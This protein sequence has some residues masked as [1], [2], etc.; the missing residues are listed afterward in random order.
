MSTKKNIFDYLNSIYY[1]NNMLYNKSDGVSCYLLSLWLS[2]D[3]N[4]INIVQKINFLQFYLSDKIIYEYY[5]YTVPKGRRFIR[6]TKKDGHKIMDDKLN[7][8]KLEYGL[9]G[10]ESKILY[11]HIKRLSIL[12]R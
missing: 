12:Y 7:E 3:K 11:D 5:F 2:H 8:L 6:W 9:S 10:I 1:K 4:L